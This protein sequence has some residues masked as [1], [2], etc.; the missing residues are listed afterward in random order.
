MYHITCF[1]LKLKKNL[2]NSNVTG[3]MGTFPTEK[4]VAFCFMTIEVIL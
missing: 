3:L 2:I 4:G 1:L